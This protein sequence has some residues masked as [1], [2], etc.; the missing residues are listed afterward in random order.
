MQT[1]SQQISVTTIIWILINVKMHKILNL[2]LYLNLPTGI[3]VSSYFLFFFFNRKKKYNLHRVNCRSININPIYY[4]F[5]FLVL[6]L[7]LFFYF[8][9]WHWPP[10][11]CLSLLDAKLW[12]PSLSLFFILCIKSS[13][14]LTILTCATYKQSYCHRFF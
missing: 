10:A 9:P 2:H 4:L 7:F 11:Y 5:S 3:T 14:F 13:Y 1:H 12:N 6:S 8:F